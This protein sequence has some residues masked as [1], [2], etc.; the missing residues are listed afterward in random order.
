MFWGFTNVTKS[1]Q[2]SMA[3]EDRSLHVALSINPPS[4][5]VSNLDPHGNRGKPYPGF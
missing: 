1:T 5:G 4:Y 2:T 3:T